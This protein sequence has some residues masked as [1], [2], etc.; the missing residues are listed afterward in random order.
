MAAPLLL[1]PILAACQPDPYEGLHAR[2]GT[3]RP[4][5][6]PWAYRRDE[7]IV[8][9]YPGV[10]ETEWREPE[11][12]VFADGVGPSPQAAESDARTNLGERV[13]ALSVGR[14]TLGNR[15]GSDGRTAVLLSLT[16]RGAA[17]EREEALPGGNVVVRLRISIEEVRTLC[18]ELVRTGSL[19]M[20]EEE[21]ARLAFRSSAYQTLM[22]TSE[23]GLSLLV[24]T[25]GVESLASSSVVVS[26]AATGP[27][28]VARIYVR[29]G[30]TEQSIEATGRA[31]SGGTARFQVAAPLEPGR[32]DLEV[33]AV[34][35]AGA[36]TK[37]ALVVIREL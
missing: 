15:L 10:G 37:I 31:D 16:L 20:S 12:A 30:R 4:E 25:P 18:R 26:G 27:S 23:S 22:R 7:Q 32:N 9:T 3:E 13:R 29:N 11:A 17:R 2:R 35:P 5:T 6:G 19:P 14:D 33:I 36:E 8:E 24:A 1:A 21:I 28:G 34:D